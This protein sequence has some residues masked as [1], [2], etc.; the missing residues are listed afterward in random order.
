MFKNEGVVRSVKFPI[1]C[2]L[3]QA[4]LAKVVHKVMSS[5]DAADN[6]QHITEIAL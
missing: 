3:F 1:I 2:C 4:G 6:K 5:L